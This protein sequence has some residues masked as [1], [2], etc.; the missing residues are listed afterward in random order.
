MGR[1]SDMIESFVE[2]YELREPPMLYAD[3]GV[4][5]REASLGMLRLDGVA[6]VSLWE[7]LGVLA[8]RTC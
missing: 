3:V 6:S 2:L 5:K 8:R 4:I 7:R 1:S